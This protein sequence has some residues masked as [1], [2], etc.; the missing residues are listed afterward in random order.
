MSIFDSAQGIQGLVEDGLPAQT[1][2]SAVN[3]IQ[4]SINNI[5]A[6][7]G[8]TQNEYVQAAYTHLNTAIEDVEKA[9]AA[10]EG[11]RDSLSSFLRF[12]LG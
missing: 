1:L 10:I 9:R 11:A 2:A 3:D 5:S 8:D 7:V 4:E 12:L 6:M